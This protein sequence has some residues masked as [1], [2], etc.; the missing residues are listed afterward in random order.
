MANIYPVEAY[1]NSMSSSRSFIIIQKRALPL[2]DELFH[3]MHIIYL[4]QGSSPIFK[5]PSFEIFPSFLK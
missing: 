3:T 2:V 4:W 5:L 1:C